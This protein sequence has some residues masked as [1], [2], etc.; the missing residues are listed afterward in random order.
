MTPISQL[1]TVCRVVESLRA[2]CSCDQ[3]RICRS[4]HNEN[5]RSHTLCLLRVVI[6]DAA[7]EFLMLPPFAL[8]AALTVD[9]KGTAEGLIAGRVEN[10]RFATSG[11]GADSEG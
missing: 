4:S 1:L 2:I 8:A 3:P 9:G 6:G 11:S 7:G 5:A 10:L